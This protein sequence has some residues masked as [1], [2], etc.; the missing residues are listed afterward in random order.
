MPARPPLRALLIDLSGTLHVGNEA[1]PGAVHA[2]GR[3]RAA[4]IPFRF[5]SNTSKESTESMRKR[6]EAMGFSGEG[7]IRSEELWTSIG[8]IGGV[9]RQRGIR[10][11][12]ILASESA[13]EDIIHHLPDDHPDESQPH[14]AVVMAFAPSQLSYEYLDAAFRVLVGEHTSQHDTQFSAKLG[15]GRERAPLLV[16]HRSRI[17]QGSDGALSMALGPF[18]TAL[19]HAS[20]SSAEIVGKPARSFF[21][22]VINSFNETDNVLDIDDYERNRSIAIIG[23]DVE[24]DLGGGAAELGLWRVLVQTGKYRPGVEKK[25]GIRSPD[26][27]SESFASFVEDLLQTS[28]R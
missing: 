1:T 22:T 5:C 25:E 7:G 14:D 19:E 8:V 10:R 24:S 13:K 21:Q 26:E 20:G 17:L 16:T 3:L 28:H 23:D 18:V 11:P 12:L 4:N 27:I 15:D 6:L 9:L 2:L